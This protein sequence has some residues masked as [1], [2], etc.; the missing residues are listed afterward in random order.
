MLHTEDKTELLHV[1][2]VPGDTV[3]VER[4]RM[5]RFLKQHID[6]LE[7]PTASHHVSMIENALP[8]LEFSLLEDDEWEAEKAAHVSGGSVAV[9]IQTG[10]P[11]SRFVIEDGGMQKYFD[12]T[13]TVFHETEHGTNNPGVGS[14]VLSLLLTNTY[15]QAGRFTYAHIRPCST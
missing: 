15:H 14:M 8:C 12:V 7:A 4:Y 2:T 11:S 1:V 3:V 6:I 10:K 5:T 13:Y 9:D